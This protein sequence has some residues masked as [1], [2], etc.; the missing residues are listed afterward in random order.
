MKTIKKPFTVL[1]T[2][3][4][5]IPL[6]AI[7]FI[8][9][10]SYADD[11][12]LVQGLITNGTAF[13]AGKTYT[14]SSSLIVN[15]SVNFNGDVINYTSTAGGCLLIQTAGVVVQNG[16]IQ[17]TF[18]PTT[19]HT[20]GA[21]PSGIT[22]YADN[23]TVT[24]MTIKNITNYGIVVSGA[25]NKPV[26]TYNNI[27][28]TGY[29]SFFYDSEAATTGG[30]LSNNVIDRSQIAP[31][32]VHQPAI[33]IR[34]AGAGTSPVTTGWTIANNTISMPLN[35]TDWSSEGIEVRATTN[36]IVTGNTF[37]QSTISISLVRCTGVTVSGN[38]CNNAQLEGIEIADSNNSICSNNIIT[39]GIGLG[40]LIDGP[41]GSNGT[42]ITG[43][44]IS[45]TAKDC[46]QAV[47]HAQN[48]KIANATLTAGTNA[49]ALNLAG[50][51]GV[52][53]TGTTIN[54]NNSAGQTAVY[55]TNCAGNLTINGGTITNFAKCLLY[56]SNSTT[57]LVTDN[58]S[59]TGN[60][61]KGVPTPLG[62]YL[63]NGSKVGTNVKVTLQ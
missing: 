20:A 10:F 29:I 44:I 30:T 46:I 11:T 22:I 27:L 39:G 34:G 49:K 52:T 42:T 55:L 9:K 14:V 56:I 58:I 6:F 2:K 60:T 61:V 19:A 41:V 63:I 62:T 51:T 50:T 43:D 37:N 7:L 25:R 31:A 32:S 57:G 23:V 45:G 36:S 1:A 38:K 24:K 33:A 5:A 16:T 12:A 40:Y 59:V 15:K 26:I 8:P 35:P 21:G 17:G 18:T 13:P 4:L 47:A 48:I 28:N 54:G 53:V 3:C